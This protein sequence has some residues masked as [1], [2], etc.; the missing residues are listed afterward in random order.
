MMSVTEAAEPPIW[1]AMLPHTFSA[2]TTRTPRTVAAAGSSPQPAHS[3]AA[4]TGDGSGSGGR[5]R[6]QQQGSGCGGERTG[7]SLT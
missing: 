5:R 4:A 3:S 6:R 7:L 1:R 2:A